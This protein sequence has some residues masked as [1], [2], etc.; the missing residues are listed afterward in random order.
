MSST[1]RKELD[2][3]KNEMPDLKAVIRRMAV[4]VSQLHGDVGEIKTF[5]KTSVATKDDIS[6]LNTRM[7]GFSGLLRDS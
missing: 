7:D 1:M 3:V 2:G 6:A 4:S 5:L